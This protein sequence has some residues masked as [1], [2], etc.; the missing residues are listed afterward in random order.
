M[1]T[2]NDISSPQPTGFDQW[3]AM[4]RR[5]TVYKSSVNLKVTQV[6]PVSALH[7]RAIR[8]S[9]VP[10]QQSVA[11]PGFVSQAFQNQAAYAMPLVK[12]RYVGMMTGQHDII[13]IKHACKTKTLF[14]AKDI[15]DD[16]EFS[17]YT[18]YG[19]TTVSGP[20]TDHQWYWVLAA[21]VMAG[22][23]VS[24]DQTL[25]IYWEATYWVEFSQSVILDD[26]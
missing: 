25:V 14:P 12:S 4:F 26:S 20:T 22:N 24:V 10:T 17:G 19:G 18:G 15:Q 11:S 5:F 3:G 23:A 9:L 13:S 16:E 1:L 8:V 2:G 21:Q 7:Q 6:N